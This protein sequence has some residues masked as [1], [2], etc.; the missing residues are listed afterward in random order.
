[1][2]TGKHSLQAHQLCWA[3]VVRRDC[4]PAGAKV[5]YLPADGAVVRQRFW[6]GLLDPGC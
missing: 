2:S 5:S 3:G 6:E 1:M 4:H